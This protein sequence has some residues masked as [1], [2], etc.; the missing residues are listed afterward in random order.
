[1]WDRKPKTRTELI[2]WRLETGRSPFEEPHPPFVYCRFTDTVSFCVRL[3]AQQGIESK[4]SI[5]LG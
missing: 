1:M 3:L 2:Q 5:S 4:V